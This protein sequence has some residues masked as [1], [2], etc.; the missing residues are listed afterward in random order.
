MSSEAKSP[1][2]V[3][4]IG[5]VLTLSTIL[6]LI[7]GALTYVYHTKMVDRETLTFAVGAAATAAGILA[8]FYI[9]KGLQGTI[10]QHQIA[11]HEDSVAAALAFSP[12][13]N[14]PRRA[15]QREA[16]RALIRQCRETSSA[17]G[18]IT[19]FNAGDDS[20][21]LTYDVLNFF[22]H[23][24][25]SVRR[26]HADFDTISATFGDMVKEYWGQSE[27]YVKRLRT[28]ENIFALYEQL[29]WLFNQLSKDHTGG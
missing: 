2:Q 15:K 24:S 6:A 17:E 27:A 21:S 10:E 4:S 14:D 5:V 19:L 22:E 1:G 28:N 26:E 12:L 20:R 7:V 3:V 9:G 8:A 23:M 29:E 25:D 13:W 16:W 18:K 11:S